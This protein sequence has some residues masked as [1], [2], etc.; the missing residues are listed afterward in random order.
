MR[1]L[2]VIALI[3]L[4]LTSFSQKGRF[5]FDMFSPYISANEP[6]RWGAEFGASFR[7]A[8]EDRICFGLGFYLSA[9][10]ESGPTDQEIAAYLP[11]CASV[12]IFKDLNFRA[13]AGP[14]LT[15]GVGL[16]SKFKFDLQYFVSRTVEG[17]VPLGVYLTGGST[18][19]ADESADVQIQVGIGITIF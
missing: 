8:P 17:S 3:L 16:I 6:N 4:A 2:L 11:F 5:E 19:L 7:A 15:S 18:I 13:S 14:T 12:R 10:T 1:R 9:G